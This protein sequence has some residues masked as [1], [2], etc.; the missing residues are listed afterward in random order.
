MIRLRDYRDEDWPALCVIHDAARRDELQAA[1]L[2]DAFLTLAETAENE[3]LFDG[4]MVVATEGD[5][6][7]GFAAWRDHELTWLYVTPTRSGQGIGRRLLRHVIAACQGRLT[8]EVL[9]GNDRALALY[10]SEG[11]TVDR[12]NSGRLTGNESFAA[13]GWLLSRGAVDAR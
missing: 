12:V 9:V 1:G 11:F 2:A 5:A 10:R 13:S 4:E 7:V 3:G 6:P 8:T